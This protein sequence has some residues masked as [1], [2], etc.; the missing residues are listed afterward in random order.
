MHM[1]GGV[2]YLIGGIFYNVV[3]I[4]CILYKYI[5]IYLCFF[6]NICIYVY[7]SKFSWWLMEEFWF[8]KLL[9]LKEKL[10]YKKKIVLR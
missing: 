5:V 2:M 6:E 4:K 3:I 7:V 9:D 10:F 1:R 8:F